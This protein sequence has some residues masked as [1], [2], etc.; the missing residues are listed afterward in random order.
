MDTI[1]Q[2][3]SDRTFQIHVSQGG[4]PKRAVPSTSISIDGLAGDLQHNL[5]V[6]GGPDRAAC[7]YSLERIQALQADE[8]PI[9]PEAIGENLTISGLDWTL[10]SPG[11]RFII[12][13]DVILQV[14]GYT[15]PCNSI[16]GA[17]SDQYAGRVSQ[18]EHHGWS[19]VYARVL[20]PGTIR[21][22]DIVLLENYLQ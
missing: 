6:H 5:M 1:N 19:R 17:F 15:S 4:V 20:S 12:G 7:I 21:I 16:V 18:V 14:T 10:V 13:K 3:H 22:A 8:H 2:Q 9:Y 11:S